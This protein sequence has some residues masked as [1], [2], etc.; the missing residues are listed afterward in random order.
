MVAMQKGG[1]K[2][3]VRPGVKVT[4]WKRH[5]VCITGTTGGIK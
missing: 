2:R 3:D 1:L 5:R 4:S